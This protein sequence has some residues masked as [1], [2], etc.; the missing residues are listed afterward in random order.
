MAQKE[1]ISKEIKINIINY[2]CGRWDECDS[3]LLNAWL[4][5]SCENRHLFGQLVHLWAADQIIRH[6][7]NFDQNKA[8]TRLEAGLDR[9]TPVRSRFN[10]FGQVF[11]YAAIL[12]LAVLA[13]GIGYHLL[14]RYTGN[15][16][17]SDSL[18][19]YSTP[20]GSKTSLRLPDGSLVRLNAGTTL[21]Y[22]Q[23]FGIRNR[24]INLSGEAYFEVA[25]NK[26]L[27][28]IVEAKEVSVM[29]LGTEFN[30]KAYAE[31]KVIET[32][33]VEGSVKI[34]N[35]MKEKNKDFLLH[36]GQ[37]AML[38]TDRPEFFVSPVADNS[39]VSW[40]TDVWIIRNTKLNALA[41]LLK[42]R[43]DVN[44]KFEDERIKD[45]E[46]GGTIKD[47]TIEQV[48]TA[49]TYSAPVNYKIINNQ[50]ILSIN[51]KNLNKYQTLFK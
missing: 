1:S 3:N 12:I 26:K 49:I 8:W 5:E 22:N 4:E 41:T 48:L 15:I 50:V 35:K 32:I 19:E 51:E 43:Y 44:F 42:R 16:V 23:E 36:P 6:E 17:S 45:Y 9:K 37:K 7:K 29:A 18:S 31:E 25:K 20:Y 28:F 21:K 10:R 13:G 46:F 39:D 27:P 11:R 40:T 47:E 2:L 30:V 34:Q 33:L 24:K 14:Q 38:Y